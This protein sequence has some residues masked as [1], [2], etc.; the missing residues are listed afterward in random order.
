MR[1]AFEIRTAPEESDD[2]LARRARVLAYRL[3]R[4]ELVVVSPIDRVLERLGDGFRVPPG[5]A[6]GVIPQAV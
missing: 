3:A 5:S 1:M 4:G 6:Q 2:S